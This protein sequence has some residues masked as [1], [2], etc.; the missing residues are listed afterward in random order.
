MDIA[1]SP[2]GP[3]GRQPIRFARTAKPGGGFRLLSRLDPADLRHLQRI[4]AHLGP[5]L[6]AFL[7]P[8]VRANRLSGVGAAL[9]P[10]GPARRAWALE[11]D[12]RLRAG[13]SKVL[14][15]D[16]RDC[17]ASI[18]GPV[19]ARAI[20]RAGG[21]EE[22]AQGLLDLLAHLHDEGV[23]G[24]PV[25]PEPSAVLANLV[26][27]GADRTLR[28]AG[29]PHIRWVDDFV[30]F[31]AGRVQSQRALDAL[32]RSMGELGLELSEPKTEILDADEAR[33]RLLTGGMPA[34]GPGVP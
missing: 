34:S 22:L 2:R 26:L 24:L 6:E 8:E 23:R 3:R 13:P 7:G 20:L 21:N 27:A 16:V 18:R 17:Y 14:V 15:T 4:V 30:V 25:G 10:W 29:A 12:R 32:R 9:I 33:A 19:L 11:I 5:R 1:S 28:E 31:T